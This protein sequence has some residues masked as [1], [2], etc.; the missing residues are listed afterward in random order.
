MIGAEETSN[1][2]T[3]RQLGEKLLGVI[4]DGYGAQAE[5]D[6]VKVAHRPK[7]PAC[8]CQA[9]VLPAVWAGISSNSHLSLAP[10]AEIRDLRK[11]L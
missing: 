4:R 11:Q 8:H 9:V 7:H 2:T 3:E 5:Q 1:E 10:V 6:T